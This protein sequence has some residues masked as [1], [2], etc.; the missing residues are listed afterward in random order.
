MRKPRPTKFLPGDRLRTL[1]DLIAIHRSA[2]PWVY[3]H[4]RP[5]HTSFLVNLSVV[6]MQSCAENG[7]LREAMLNPAYKEKTN[8]TPF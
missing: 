4:G 1:A 6:I 8:A 5:K 3:W 7:R 2:R